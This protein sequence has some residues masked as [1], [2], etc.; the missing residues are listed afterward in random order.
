MLNARSANQQYWLLSRQTPSARLE[1]AD[2]WWT[3]KELKRHKIEPGPLV[4]PE[5]VSPRFAAI[6]HRY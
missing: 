6:A 5:R 3:R 1:W 4:V 2:Y